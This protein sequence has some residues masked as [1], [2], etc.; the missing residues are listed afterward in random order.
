MTVVVEVDDDGRLIESFLEMMAAERGAARNTLDA[1]RRDLEAASVAF[2]AFGGSLG[3]SGKPE[4]VRY[5]KQIGDEGQAPTTR[6]RRLS[7]LRQFYKFLLAEGIVAEDPTRTLAG[8]KKGR[9]LPRFLSVAE[10]ERLLDTAKVRTGAL[11]GRDRLR[12]LRLHALLEVLYATGMRVSELVTLPRNVL[13]ADERV[14]TIRGKGGK[15][16]IVPLNGAARRALA[17]YMA[18]AAADGSPLAEVRSKWLFPSRGAEGHLT[19]QRLGQE[20]KELAEAA[21][22]SP[23]RVSP[24][25]LRH[26]FA[27]HLLDRGADL[28][29]VQQLLGHADIATTE[30]YTHVLEERLKKVVLEHHPL[31][32]REPKA[33]RA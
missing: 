7:S 29:A 4:V 26:A 19:R 12:A 28:R 32:R 24:H 14:L 22:L 2:A 5:L 13:D 33:K 8:P 21:G 9:A 25:V 6:A 18:E 31:A 10:V 15:E 27:S 11:E 23:D 3:R 16:R 1:Y 30:I 20:L 17:R